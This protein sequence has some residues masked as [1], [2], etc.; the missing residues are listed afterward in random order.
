VRAWGFGGFGQ[1]TD[2]SYPAGVATPELASLG[3]PV[4]AIAAGSGHSLALPN[5]PPTLTIDQP[6]EGASFAGP[7][8][9]T[10]EATASDSDGVVTKVDFYNQSCN[11]NILLGT[12][13]A[14]PYKFTM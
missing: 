9:V 4:S 6:L 14:P 3:Q 8:D 7:I 13:T 10:I 1:L 11:N 2:N 12:V 5:N